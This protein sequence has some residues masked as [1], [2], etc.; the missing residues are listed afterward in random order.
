MFIEYLF[1]LVQY[2]RPLSMSESLAK[3]AQKID[4]SKA[5]AEEIVKEIGDQQD[6]N[7]EDSAT[8]EAA[9]FQSSLWPWDSVRNKLRYISPL[10]C[11]RFNELFF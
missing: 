5:S 7:D 8:K 3:L 4:F 11:K 1:S 2:S 9:T 6:K 10:I